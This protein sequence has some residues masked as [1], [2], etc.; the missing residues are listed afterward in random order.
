MHLDFKIDRGT[1]W[2]IVCPEVCRLF[3][4]VL[5]DGH[6]YDVDQGSTSESRD[7]E[8]GCAVG[9]DAGVGHLCSNSIVSICHSIEKMN[10]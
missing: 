10:W 8:L 9:Q 3:A 5:I 6:R 1:L 2:K 4:I 7:W